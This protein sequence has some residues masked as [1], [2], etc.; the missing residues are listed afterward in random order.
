M[1]LKGFLLAL[2]AVAMLFAPLA[3]PGGQALAA[4]PMPQASASSEHCQPSDAAKHH[5]G[6]R[7]QT[8]CATMCLALAV[9]PG[10]PMAAQ[11]M[12]RRAFRPSGDRQQRSFVAKLPTPPPR[13]A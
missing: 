6:E 8:D 11:L 10:Q 9:S 12:L 7:D 13:L 2:L 3:M 1:K 4:A 5:D